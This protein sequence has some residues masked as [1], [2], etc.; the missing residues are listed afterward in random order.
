VLVEVN[1]ES[2]FVARTSDFQELVKDIAMQIAAAD[3]RFVRREEVTPEILQR[4]REIYVQQ[5]LNS[6]KPKPVVE[7]IVDGKM[8]K[9]YS[10][11]C[12]MEQAFIKDP[13]TTIQ[14]LIAAKVAKIGENIRINR[15]ARFKVGE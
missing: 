11:A 5:A 13:K 9:F 4:E 3:P 6:G 15:F 2:D 14:E 1:C 7:K 10:E 12:L 8:E